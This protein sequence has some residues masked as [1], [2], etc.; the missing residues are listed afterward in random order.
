MA[1]PLRRRDGGG[2]SRTCDALCRLQPGPR[3]AF[4]M[5]GGLAVVECEAAPNG[6]GQRA[7]RRS[8]GGLCQA[9]ADLTARR[10]DEKVALCIRLN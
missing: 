9:L 6:E 10:D 8:P 1:G 3:E 4:R 7:R 2:A 5:G